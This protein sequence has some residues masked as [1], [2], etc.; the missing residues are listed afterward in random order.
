MVDGN[1]SDFKVLFDTL[2]NYK[3]HI[4]KTFWIDLNDKHHSKNAI[5]YEYNEKGNYIIV[6]CKNRKKQIFMIK[7][8]IFVK[9][10]IA[11]ILYFLTYTVLIQKEQAK[12]KAILI[13]EKMINEFEIYKI[14]NSLPKGSRKDMR[15]YYNQIKGELKLL[16][17]Q[18]S[19]S[20]K[21]IN[22]LNLMRDKGKF[23][24]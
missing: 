17:R 15:V 16:Q 8:K 6:W 20:V 7:Y 2:Q 4:V 5:H 10:E 12:I 19:H 21:Y 18:Y 9:D 24:F 1:I 3:P 11:N 14:L 22:K 13:K 23:Y